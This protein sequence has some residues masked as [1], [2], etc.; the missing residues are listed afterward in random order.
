MQKTDKDLHE[1]DIAGATESL[2]LEPL[3]Q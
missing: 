1:L 3:K 2:A